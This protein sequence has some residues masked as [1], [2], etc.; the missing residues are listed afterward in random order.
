ML[1]EGEW[2]ALGEG[3]GEDLRIRQRRRKGAC[4]RALRGSTTGALGAI[5]RFRG[6]HMVSSM[7]D[8]V[9]AVYKTGLL[10]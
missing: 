7:P 5:Y 3:S 9:M 2:L 10:A 8:R 6:E 4:L 1:A